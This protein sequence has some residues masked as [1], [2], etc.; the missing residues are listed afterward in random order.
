MAT[1][2][3][4]PSRSVETPQH[5][6]NWG[7]P[8][9]VNESITFDE[10][11]QTDVDRIAEMMRMADGSG[12]A[13]V[14]VYKVENGV[15]TYCQGYQPSDFEEGDYDML[16]DAFGAGKF[17]IMLYGQ[18]PETNRFG[19]R[20]R[21]EIAIAENRSAK[22][23]ENATPYDS[24]LAQVLESISKGQNQLLEALIAIKQA[25]QKDP[26]D[27]M[28]KMLTMMSLM[29]ES[30]GFNNSQNQKSSIGEIVAAVRELRE[31]ASEITPGKETPTDADS[32]SAML[33]KVLEIIQTGMT[34]RNQ[35]PLQENNTAIMPTVN[36]PVSMQPNNEDDMLN[37]FGIFK[38]RGYLKSLVAMAALEQDPQLGAE[39]IYEKL[40]DE[41]IEMLELPNW[42]DALK[43]FEESVS[44]HEVWLSKARDIALALFNAPDDADTPQPAV[45]V[46]P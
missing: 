44:T 32:M 43:A 14:K 7:T 16:R 26:M 41:M 5:P 37:P 3:R 25:P 20:A 27:E 4:K 30:M 8:L 12:R 42:F 21:T 19:I 40:P 34:Q 15:S 6:D 9:T 33:P 24:G 29:R 22:R 17:K 31:V 36:L 1:I 18:D 13:I 23:G 10:P 2:T 45:D 28:S 46:K 39:L 38:L 11:E 35:T